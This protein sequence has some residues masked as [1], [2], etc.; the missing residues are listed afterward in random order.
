MEVTKNESERGK[1]RKK[2]NKKRYSP[3]RLFVP[4]LNISLWGDLT[5][6]SFPPLLRLRSDFNARLYHT[7]AERHAQRASTW[8]TLYGMR[9][10][11]LDS[12]NH[13]IKMRCWPSGVQSFAK[14]T[15]SIKALVFVHF[16]PPLDSTRPIRFNRSFYFL[17]MGSRWEN[18]K[19][20]NGTTSRRLLGTG[21]RSRL[22]RIALRMGSVYIF[23]SVV[24]KTRPFVSCAETTATFNP[25]TYGLFVSLA[26][27]T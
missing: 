6:R 11:S 2:E 24:I 15:T 23:I 1:E 20:T 13:R 18:E 22:L 25:I 10:A 9:S 3:W 4:P 19:K 27:G 17:P 21:R 5:R 7:L 14:A 16:W 8:R 26:E 12:V